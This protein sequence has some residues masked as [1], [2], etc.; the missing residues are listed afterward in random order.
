V[1]IELC[2][3]KKWPNNMLGEKNDWRGMKKGG[4]IHIFPQ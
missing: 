3:G 1:Y 2:L 4:E